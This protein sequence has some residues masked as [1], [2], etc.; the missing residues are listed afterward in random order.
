MAKVKLWTRQDVRFLDAIKKEGVFHAK[1]EYIEEKNQELSL[2][3]LKLYDWFVAEASKRV[4]R[5]DGAQYPIWCSVNSEYMLRGAHGNILIELSI[6]EER[7]VYFDSPKWDL[8]LNHYY[9]AKDAED[10]RRFEAEL[11]RRGIRNSFALLDEFHQKFYPDLAQKVM[12]SW[13]RIFDVDKDD[14]NIFAVQANIWAIY[15]ED[16]VEIREGEDERKIKS[17]RIF[18]ELRPKE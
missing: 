7:I 12:R 15:P 4:P 2:Y 17:V 16:I 14:E 5:P 6:D 3:F 9:I 10:Q 8:V 1:K 11:D 18:E 13:E